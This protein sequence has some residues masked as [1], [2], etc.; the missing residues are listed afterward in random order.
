MTESRQRTKKLTSMAMLCAL[1]YL[2][3]LVGRIP[4][5]LFLKYDPKDIVIAIGGFL[6]GPVS[7]FVISAVV[8]VIELP[9]S[10]TSYI[11]CVM[12]LIS[13]AAFA[14]TAAYI[15]SKNRTLRGAVI[16]LVTG[17]LVMTGVML[18]WNYF[19]TPIYMGYP[20][21]AVVDLLLPVFLPFNLLKGGLNA[22][23]TMLIY[24][25]V[26]SALRA[27]GLVP[28]GQVH[29]Q[30]SRRVTIGVMLVSLLV[31]ITCILLVLV[32]KKVI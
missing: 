25:P 26:V 7:A 12:N 19:L 23:F 11:G 10:D 13:S 18:L 3:M 5:T 9:I 32:M 20:R 27:S 6:Y 14:C 30:E 31:L 21:E 15:Y 22:A 28:E 29:A 2:M 4:V 24:K 17:V 16:G 8:A 1:A